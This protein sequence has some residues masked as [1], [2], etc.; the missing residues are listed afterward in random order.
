MGRKILSFLIAAMLLFSCATTVFAA[1][2][3]AHTEPHSQSETLHLMDPHCY[4]E[5]E[6]PMEPHDH[7]HSH[8]HDHEYDCDYDH[9][10]A[11]SGLRGDEDPVPPPGGEET[12]PEQHEALPEEQEVPSEPEDGKIGAALPSEEEIEPALPEVPHEEPEIPEYFLLQTR[13]GAA[14]VVFGE[15]DEPSAPIITPFLVG[16]RPCSFQECPNT[17][18]VRTKYD[19]VCDAHK[20]SVSGCSSPL[21]Y[22]NPN[23]CQLHAGLTNIICQ[24]YIPENPNGLCGKPSIGNGSICCWE[25]H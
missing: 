21:Y 22:Q 16:S 18:T 24:I 12:E 3:E 4:G 14:I 6:Y 15:P 17:V 11:G 20:C 13:S 19:F 9:A 10:K 25:H 5:T 23:K 1:E 8:P 2:S 7:S